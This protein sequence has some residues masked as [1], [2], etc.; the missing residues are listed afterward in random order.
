[1][2]SVFGDFSAA[3]FSEI[4]C[5]GLVVFCEFGVL[6]LRGRFVF[7]DFGVLG[8]LVWWPFGFGCV[9]VV[10]MAISDTKDMTLNTHTGSSGPSPLSGRR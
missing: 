4:R 8:R 10:S 7:G 9:S 3:A 5:L 1:M 6:R 2:I